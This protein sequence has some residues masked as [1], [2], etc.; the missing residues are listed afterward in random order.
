MLAVL[1]SYVC[2]VL[3]RGVLCSVCLVYVLMVVPVSSELRNI[4]AELNQIRMFSRT[5]QEREI[6]PKPIKHLRF[7]ETNDHAVTMSNDVTLVENP[8]TTKIQEPIC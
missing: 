3:C 6:R 8:C 4:E 7:H 1:S 5:S 2:V